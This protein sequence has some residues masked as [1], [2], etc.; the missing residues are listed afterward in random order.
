[1]RERS[2]RTA[3]AVTVPTPEQVPTGTYQPGMQGQTMNL[4]SVITLKAIPINIVT[5]S[6]ITMDGAAVAQALQKYMTQDL[7]YEATSSG[8]LSQ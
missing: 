5:T 2:E 6:M 1:M 3:A 4:N 8:A 7:V